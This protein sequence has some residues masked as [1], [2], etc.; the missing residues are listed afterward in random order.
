M[1]AAAPK[2]NPG[3]LTDDELVTSFCVRNA[4][5]ESVMETLRNCRGPSN[6]HQ[7]VV[8]P[9]GS[10][11][12]TLL[13][14]VAAEVR[15]DPALSRDFFPIQ[16]AEESY[17]VATAGEFWLECLSRLADQAPKRDGDPDLDLTVAELRSVR[18]DRDLA[19]RCLGALL[20]FSDR[21]GKRLV[22]LVENL[23]MMFREMADPDV[24]PRLRE[25]LQNEP[26]IVVLGSATS[27]FAQITDPAEALSEQLRI[28]LL[29]PLDTEACRVLWESVSGRSA[30]QHSIRSLE[31]LTGGSA[32][33]L[34]VV[35]RFGSARSFRALLADL[36]DLVDNHTEY[37]KSH[38]EAL[39]PQ[40]RRV[41]LALAEL[42]Q[43][44]TTRE[45]AKR[46][47]LDTSKCSA[48]LQR[49]MERDVVQEK[50]GTARRKEYYLT[51]RL[52]NIY[53]LLRRRRGH[54]PLVEALIRFMQSFYRPSEIQEITAQ[55]F[56][57]LG[58]L[59]PHM[60]EMYQIALA[61]LA[62]P[63][64]PPAWEPAAELHNRG[65]VLAGENR[66]NEA[67]S[68]WN[69]VVTRYGTNEAQSV[70]V[71]VAMALNNKAG[72]L[73]QL[74][75]P[76]EALAASEEV[77]RRFGDSGF[78][79]LANQAAKSLI[80]RGASLAALGRWEEALAS[81]QHV[82]SRF[83]ASED[84]DL[85][86]T[87]AM[88]LVN[89][90]GVLE[91]LHRWQEAVAL[92]DEVV[93]R[94]HEHQE[95]RVLVQVAIALVNKGAALRHASRPAEALA[96]W[97]GVA[98]RFDK[99]KE[100]ELRSQVAKALV[101]AGTV[102][103]EMDRSEDALAAWEEVVRSYGDSNEPVLLES[104]GMALGN[105]GSVFN[106]LGR[107]ADA[108]AVCDEIVHRLGQSEAAALRKRTVGTLVLKGALLGRLDRREEAVAAFE[109]ALGRVSGEASED[110][111]RLRDLALLGR[112]DVQ[113]KRA[114][115][116]AVIESADLVLADS[117]A[118]APD[119]RWRA[120]AFRA[121]AAFLHGDVAQSERDITD[122][123][124][125]LADWDSPPKDAIQSLLIL[126]VNLGP[127]EMLRLIEAS[128]EKTKALLLPLSTALHLDLERSPRVAVEVE[129]VAKDLR[130]DL[131]ELRRDA[132]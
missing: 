101:N 104:V 63:Q 81:W 74:N 106:K 12:T 119:V 21:E 46:C 58:Q 96:A 109:D 105:K 91:R 49:L 75:R 123:L 61:R 19:T 129:E 77:V 32:R 65:I 18:E 3:F 20:D 100:L 28:V 115:Y 62:K 132:A 89:R 6:A 17:A 16:F 113:L 79:A 90:A 37:F 1:P 116:Q 131:A 103:D 78:P 94:F 102:L 42:W 87:V 33:L 117:H 8:G 86:E 52:Y 45:I 39:P 125:V 27:Q 67:V 5:F 9:R 50:G 14:R 112:A 13:L 34:A 114:E 72:A 23:N 57:E 2:Y 88:A 43:P 22:L 4:E 35:A 10:G 110:F 7:I 92:L 59:G 84:P 126:T 53:Y 121:R 107:T 64:I 31:I 97:R 76:G 25:V 66:L 40:E 122:L 82:E 95:S 127:E 71:V 30:A 38:L 11:K 93:R 73:G 98:R 47:R 26:R 55:M 83:G 111:G 51:E 44:A 54:A 41:Y 130:S 118:K 108:A 124:V 56:R 68:V 80:N 48:Q 85:D 70:L 128:V 60:R 36:L 99:G 69:E 29:E 24:G 120:H 15:R